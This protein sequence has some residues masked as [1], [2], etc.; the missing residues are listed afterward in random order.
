MKRTHAQPTRTAFTIVELL[1]VVALVLILLS[2]IIVAVNGAMKS[3]Q[4]TN[5]RAL[6]NSMSQAMVQFKQDIGYLPPVLNEKRDLYWDNLDPNPTDNIRMPGYNGPDPAGNENQYR[7]QMQDWYS[8]T[9]LPEYLIGYGPEEEDGRNGLGIRNP[10]NDGY[11]GATNETLGSNAGEFRGGRAPSTPGGS[12]GWLTDQASA[13]YREGRVYGPYLQLRDERL[14]GAIDP[15]EEPD[16]DGRF[17]VFFPGEEGYDASWPKVIV[18]YWGEPIR[19]YRKPHPVGS[20]AREYRVRGYRD[21]EEQITPPTLSDVFLLRPWSVSSG[22]GLDGRLADDSS[23]G[24]RTTTHAL[25]TG[26]FAMFSAGPDQ[27]FNH[28]HRVDTDG[29][30]ED[31]I[32]EVGQ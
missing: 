16:E 26:E 31:N 13:Q 18:D 14:L 11:W 23:I 30:N 27:T 2:I 5:T 4:T 24:D 9:S 12:D 29:V 19:Y 8:V 7:D 17:R 32:V 25:Q 10:G 22:E 1:V 3:A 20:I 28:W 6:M 15:N 21:G